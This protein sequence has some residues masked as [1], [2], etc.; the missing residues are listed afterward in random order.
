[1][2]RA[3]DYVK[4]KPE[5][6]HQLREQLGNTTLLLVARNG[7]LV[8]SVRDEHANVYKITIGDP[9]SCSCENGA[10]GSELC[11]HKLYCL[12]KVL[13]IHEDHPLSYQLGLTDSEVE[14]VLSGEC[15]NHT[16]NGVE[17][18]SAIARERKKALKNMKDVTKE[19]DNNKNEYV[20]RQLLGEG[21]DETCPICQDQMN[22]DQALTWCRKGCGNNIHAKCM[23]TFAQYKVTN[24]QG[25]S[26]PLCREDWCIELLKD[27]VRGKANLKNSPAPIYCSSCSQ[28]IRTGN[29]YR[30]LECSHR[31]AIM[32][33]Q[34]DIDDQMT[35]MAE[36]Q[37]NQLQ[38]QEQR[39]AVQT[40]HAPM[41]M[42]SNKKR[43]GGVNGV[44]CTNQS[45][46]PPQNSHEMV[47]RAN[48]PGGSYMASQ[49][50]RTVD[51]C[52]NCFRNVGKEHSS[53]HFL[54]G[55][56]TTRSTAEDLEL[57]WEIA[58]N[59]LHSASGA[60]LLYP[61]SALAGI[62]ERELTASDYEILL[63]LDRTPHHNIG[64]HIT[65]SLPKYKGYQCDG[66]V[67][68]AKAQQARKDGEGQGSDALMILDDDIDDNDVEGGMVNVE[69]LVATNASASISMAM[70]GT[71][72]EM[73]PICWCTG[74]EVSNLPGISSE[75]LRELPCGHTAHDWCISTAM[76]KN[77]LEGL[78]F[79][80]FKCMHIGCGQSALLALTR[81]RKRR[82]SKKFFHMRGMTPPTGLDASSILTCS[83]ITT[84]EVSEVK[85][86]IPLISIKGLH[87]PNRSMGNLLAGNNRN[88]S[89]DRGRLSRSANIRHNTSVGEMS[90]GIAASDNSRQQQVSLSLNLNFGGL[91]GS[92]V[93]LAGKA[94]ITGL[95][96]HRSNNTR[97]PLSSAR[98]K[99]KK[100]GGVKPFQNDMEGQGLDGS[101]VLVHST[102]RRPSLPL[103]S[104]SNEG[105]LISM[106]NEDTLTD[107]PLHRNNQS[108]L[109]DSQPTTAD[110]QGRS[111]ELLLPLQIVDNES[112]IHEETIINPHGETVRQRTPGKDASRSGSRGGSHSPERHTS[113]ASSNRKTLTNST[114]TRAIRDQYVDSTAPDT[115]LT[116]MDGGSEEFQR[117]WGGLQSLKISD[118]VNADEFGRARITS[119]NTSNSSAAPNLP[120]VPFSQSTTLADNRSSIVTTPI[121]GMRHEGDGQLSAQGT[122]K[123]K[124]KKKSAANKLRTQIVK[125]SLSRPASKQLRLLQSQSQIKDGVQ[126]VN[127]NGVFSHSDLSYAIT[128]RKPPRKGVLNKGH[129]A[130]LTT[131]MKKE[132]WEN[133]A[134]ND[135]GICPI[136]ILPSTRKSKPLPQLELN[137]RSKSL[138]LPIALNNKARL[139]Q[140]LQPGIG[141]TRTLEID[142]AQQMLRSLTEEEIL[143]LMNGF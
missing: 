99:N 110:S 88:D 49:I 143:A 85:E 32:S 84:Q 82:L 53:H 55:E 80:N 39:A 86:R 6:W 131:P 4:K 125:S 31:K 16:A 40:S 48:T 64:A 47:E 132:E 28:S 106:T 75:A 127:M 126:T 138:L 51:Y 33:I 52:S 50:K 109:N 97:P 59:P 134:S 69:G 2:S 128:M 94:P 89:T 26:C 123:E 103:R 100:G 66:N 121:Q 45:Q 111:V 14:L 25:V 8:F 41:L 137:V 139:S 44:N 22:K 122:Q 18:R 13:R 70:T 37:Q 11:I 92:T 43:G 118:P 17:N 21:D 91:T 62:E 29:F 135:K 46:K 57:Q 65:Q 38:Q 27:D 12:I 104:L 108:P 140:Q 133:M 102:P 79:S 81:R 35:A 54:K 124:D 72:G 60:S 119:S 19:D 129:A 61:N 142:R 141:M 87:V 98:S 96:N 3:V 30:C 76:E 107:M 78:P 130:R 34:K 42:V 36:E 7:P 68:I 5:S 10:P 73:I 101:Q 93:S 105:G 67:I 71:G 20:D 1:M 116:T 24:R 9:H 56:A 136:Q 114:S 95:N 117:Q 112:D 58:A 83:T 113:A 15:S 120:L 77:R 63:E 23:Q 90:A 115:G 74:S